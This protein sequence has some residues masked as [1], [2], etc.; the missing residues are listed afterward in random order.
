MATE[1]E[2]ALGQTLEIDLLPSA[3]YAP[4]AW[5]VDTSNGGPD[6]TILSQASC[7]IRWAEEGDVYLPLPLS[8]CRIVCKILTKNMH[9][10]AERSL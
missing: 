9:N 4:N 7:E 3:G 1:V 10:R 8:H 2:L 6:P 5:A